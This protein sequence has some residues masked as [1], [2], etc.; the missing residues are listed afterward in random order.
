MI[1]LPGWL[2][3]VLDRTHEQAAKEP[4]VKSRY[5]TSG[6]VRLLSRPRKMARHQ[7]VHRRLLQ[8]GSPR[9]SAVFWLK[10]HS[11]KDPP[12]RIPPYRN[13]ACCSA[14]QAHASEPIFRGGGIAQPE[15]E[16]RLFELCRMGVERMCDG[17][18]LFGE[19]DVFA[20]GCTVPEENRSLDTGQQKRRI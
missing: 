11:A 4:T 13:G 2:R 1:V 19:C 12:I 20:K 9:L 14:T 3:L 16:N 6:I 5:S 7:P 8:P 10:S 18:C 17:R 15:H